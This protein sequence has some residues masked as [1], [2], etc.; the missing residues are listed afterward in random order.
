[1]EHVRARLDSFGAITAADLA[2]ARDGERVIVG[3][4]VVARQ[5]PE[6]A[7]GTVFLLL[8]DEHGF[9]NI[10]VPRDLY[11]ENRETVK[12]SPFLLVEGRIDR[13]G[14]VVNVV[15]RRFRE[16]R[17]QRLAFSSRDFR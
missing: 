15:G 10:I 14:P 4:L 8:E 13:D 6:T 5:H 17:L 1:M 3:G 2:G 11:A 7:K 16:L 12:F 9:F